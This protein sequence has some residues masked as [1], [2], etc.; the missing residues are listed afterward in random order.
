MIRKTA[1]RVFTD[2]LAW[3]PYAVWLLAV[4]L[5]GLTAAWLTLIWRVAATVL[6]V[7]WSWLTG[8]PSAWFVAAV[9]LNVAFLLG[10]AFAGRRP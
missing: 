2:M 6:P 9:V 8:V 4:V 1:H 5:A 3:N 7:A 10:V